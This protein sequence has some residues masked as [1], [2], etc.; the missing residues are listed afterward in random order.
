[1]KTTRRTFT[2][3]IVIG[4]VTLVL[5][6]GIGFAQDDCTLPSPGTATRFIPKEP[7]VLPRLSAA[8]LAAPGHAA[9]LK[10]FRAAIGKL[11]ALPPADVVGWTKLIA[12]HC[13][14]CAPADKNNIHFD[15]QF[16]GWHRAL[17]YFVERTLRST[18]GGGDDNVR[19]PY[20]DWEN[21]ASRTLPAIYRQVAH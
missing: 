12:Q 16:A 15:W 20:W 7:K 6:P 10:A 17:L 21:A 5:D 14:Q 2:R 1:M 3:T 9:Q 4:S 11:R 19:L 18:I 13:I 8:E